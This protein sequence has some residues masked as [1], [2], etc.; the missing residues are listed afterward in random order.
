MSSKSE[1]SYTSSS[2]RDDANTAWLRSA[3]ASA[4]LSL[5]LSIRSIRFP[6]GSSFGEE[7]SDDDSDGWAVRRGLT[8]FFLLLKVSFRTSEAGDANDG[9][10]TGTN[11]SVF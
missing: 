5:R 11:S 4:R 9:P 7:I 1:E 2:Y 6:A 10:A 8:L 3:S